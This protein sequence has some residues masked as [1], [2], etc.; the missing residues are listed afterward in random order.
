MAKARTESEMRAALTKGKA[1]HELPWYKTDF[2]EMPEPAKTMLEKYSKILPDQVLQHVNDVRDRAFEV[3][4]YP[5][6]G[7]F[8]FLDMSIPNLPVYPEIP[9][10]TEMRSKAAGYGLCYWTRA[11]APSMLM[12]ITPWQC[13]APIQSPNETQAYDGVPSENLYASDLHKK[14]FNIGYD[15]FADRETLKTKFIASDIFDDDSDVV[16]DLTGKI[17]IVNTASFFHLFSR[18]Q[19]II[20]AKR[21]VGLLRAR[22]GSLLIGRQ[23]G[24][25]DPD[26]TNSEG[27]E[28]LLYRHNLETWKSLW[29][30]VQ[31]ETGTQWEVEGGFEDWSAYT[32][33]AMRPLNGDNPIGIWFVVRRV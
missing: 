3:F 20:V 28:S 33:S 19:Q 7:S 11:A 31:E 32:K 23:I 6:I 25:A 13:R 2:E 21:V 15:L 12:W 8:R 27:K 22:P 14:F 24:C 5:C 17:D 26:D 29:K 4:P 10:A 9:R 30:Q 1:P 16:R 18:D